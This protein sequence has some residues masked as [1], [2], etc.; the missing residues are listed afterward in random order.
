[1]CLKTRLYIIVVTH[2]PFINLLLL[3]TLTDDGKSLDIFLAATVIE[4]LNM[5]EKG[6]V[7]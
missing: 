6:V 4:E 1:M 3:S 7:N 2:L 5:L